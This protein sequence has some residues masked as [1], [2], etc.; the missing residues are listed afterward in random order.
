MYEQS[1]ASSLAPEV[2]IDEVMGELQIKGWDEPRVVVKG[3]QDDLE[4]TEQDDVVHLS[5]RGNCAVRLPGGS[6]LH[7]RSV[8]GDARFKLLE[9]QLEIDR[10]QGS[11]VLKSVAETSIGTVN[12][13]LYARNVNGDLVVD[14]V[15]GNASVREVQ[16]DCTLSKVAGDA[17]LRDMEGDVEVTASGNAWVRISQFSGSDYEIIAHGNAHVRIPSDADVELDL[18]SGGQMIRLKLPDGARE[19]HE[20]HFETTL[21]RGSCTLSVR[22]GGNLSLVAG[23]S[24]A[25]RDDA[26][27]EEYYDSFQEDINRQIEAQVN[28]LT[29]QINEQLTQLTKQVGKTGFTPEETEEIIQRA[30]ESSEKAQARALERMRLAQE[31]LE[32]KIESDLRRSERRAGQFE[33][34][35]RHNWRFDFSPPPPPAEPVVEEERLIILRMLEQK[36]ITLEEAESLLAALEGRDA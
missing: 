6:T 23:E 19:I 25:A 7:V 13:E 24:V 29:R 34:R 10:V 31:K 18:S 9:D 27:G 15:M 22:A 21:G 14:N 12:G 35:G 33:R 8:L 16:G 17:D 26:G 1:I 28:A 5:C 3:A 30:R 20:P 11:V 36:K 32:R 2:F 4:L